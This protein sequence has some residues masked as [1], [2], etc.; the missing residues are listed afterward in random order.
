MVQYT[1]SRMTGISALTGEL[2]DDNH[3]R[4]PQAGRDADLKEKFDNLAD[5]VKKD[6]FIIAG[7]LNTH[8]ENRRG[9]EEV[10]GHLGQDKRNFE[11]RDL[12]DMHTRNGWVTCFK[13]D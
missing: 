12:V 10:M 1:N 5:V 8:T 6:K 3:I 13:R 4:A 7:Y 11:G 9:C 2:T